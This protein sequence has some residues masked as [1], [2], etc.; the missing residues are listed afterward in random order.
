VRVRVGVDI[1]GVD[2]VRRL[3]AESSGV[4]ETVFTPTEL[5]YCRG[6]RRGA[7]HLAARFAGKEAVL[8]ALGT[9]LGRR[10]RWLDV[11][12][13]PGARGRPLV[14]LHGAVAEYAKSN[15]VSDVEVSLSHSVGL[16]VGQAVA[17]WPD[18]AGEEG[19]S[20]VSPH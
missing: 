8:K 18:Q 15:G 19:T 16:A 14:H 13:V 11:E 5:A 12:I 10:M 4:E 17:L 6:K 7:D 1:V 3:M 20:A 9:G 2:R